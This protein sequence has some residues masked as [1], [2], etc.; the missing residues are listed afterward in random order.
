MLLEGVQLME[1]Y[2][3]DTH[4]L[5]QYTF[6]I[7]LHLRNLFEKSFKQTTWYLGSY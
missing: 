1:A 4:H 5:P 2:S 6:K 7:L 3:Q